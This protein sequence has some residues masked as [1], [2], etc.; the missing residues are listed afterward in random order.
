MKFIPT[1]I[2][3]SLLFLSTGCSNSQK[4][5]TK[6]EKQVNNQEEK[7]EVKHPST[8]AVD[9]YASGENDT[10][11]LSVRFGGEIVFTDAKNNI[12]FS[13]DSNEKIVAQGANVV[14]IFSQNE[15]HIINVSIDI[16]TCMKTGKE[17][18]IMIREIDKKSG[19]DYVGCGYYRGTPQLHDIWALYKLNGEEL[20]AKHFPRE[21]PHFEFNLVTQQMSGFAGCN[22]V[23][24][25]LSF[26]YNRM[27]I[28]QLSSTRMYCGDASDL[29]NKILAILRDKPFYHLKDLHLIIE[30]Q[31]G[32]IT[33]KK[34]D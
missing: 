22:Q 14:Q 26:E 10:W 20:T 24:G 32:S 23:N 5:E 33:L 9:F 25:N 7:K 13:S 30:T 12:S 18:N 21:L 17:V 19:L 28:N 1:I 34:V 6:T 8:T 4:V 16:V 11:K 3:S 2:I 15:T 27:I 31:K 29:E